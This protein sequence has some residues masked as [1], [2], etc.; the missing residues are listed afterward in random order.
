MSKVSFLKD[1][2]I[3]LYYLEKYKSFFQKYIEEKEVCG[4]K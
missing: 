2:Y 4:L 3:T 1:G